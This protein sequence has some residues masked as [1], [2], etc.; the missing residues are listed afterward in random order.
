VPELPD[1]TTAEWAAAGLAA[2]LVVVLAA[3]HLVRGV[4]GRSAASPWG[5]VAGFLLG[6]IAVALVL[7]A[8]LAAAA[9][10]RAGGGRTGPFAGVLVHPD[11]PNAERL[12]SYV[13]ALTLPPAAV[14]A[15]LSLAVIEVGRPS[16]LR[17]V[18]GVASGA[19]AAMGALVVWG[20]PG[21][22][23]EAAAWFV[24]VLGAAAAVSL[25]VDELAGRRSGPG[26]GRTTA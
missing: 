11:R 15:V 18:A 26:G 17:T 9:G 7:C 16:G 12:G 21:A 5:R 8:V 25:V 10:W 2:S 14:L 22:A 13:P 23:P 1:P 24:T 4:L 3:L 20:D 6:C 19:A